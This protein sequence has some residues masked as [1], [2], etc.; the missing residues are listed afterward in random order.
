[1][2]ACAPAAVSPTDLE[3]NISPSKSAVVQRKSRNGLAFACTP[4]AVEGEL[5]FAC[6][7]T[8]IEGNISPSK[9][10]VV[11]RRSHAGL[12]FACARTEVEG[13]IL[14][15]KSGVMLDGGLNL[16]NRDAVGV[17]STPTEEFDSRILARACR[18]ELMSKRGAA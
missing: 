8:D 3:G 15:D 12:A 1:M 13:G 5:A 14:P 10:S 17:T 7:S 9:S 4:T 6:G 16:P 18:A 11:L 2:F